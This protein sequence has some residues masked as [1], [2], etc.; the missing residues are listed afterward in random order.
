MKTV[1]KEFC[2]SDNALTSIRDCYKINQ[3]MYT[4]EG[5]D[6]QKDVLKRICKNKITIEYEV[7]EKSATISE[8]DL[9][10]LFSKYGFVLTSYLDHGIMG[11]K[12]STER[13]T[14]NIIKCDLLKQK[15]FGD[16]NEKN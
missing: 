13:S 6:R 16:K 3:D 12:M 10:E 9:D 11:Y 4:Q 7:P 2:V 5:L 1:K 15:L 14:V 8:S